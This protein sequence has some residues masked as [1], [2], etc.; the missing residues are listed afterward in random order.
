MQ[1]LYYDQSVDPKK[2][3]AINEISRVQSKPRRDTD[4]KATMLLDYAATYPNAVFFIKPETCSF[5][6]I[7]TRR[8]SPFQRKDVLIL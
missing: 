4:E 2:L 5:M 8:I 3:R 1:L 6:W 7:H